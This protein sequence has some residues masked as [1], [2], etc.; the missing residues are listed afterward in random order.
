MET[1]EEWEDRKAQEEADRVN[2]GPGITTPTRWISPLQTTYNE[3]GQ[4]VNTIR[5]YGGARHDELDW[6]ALNRHPKGAPLGQDVLVY[7][8]AGRDV[9]PG[10]YNLRRSSGRSLPQERSH[11]TRAR[12]ACR[13][14]RSTCR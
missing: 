11:S 9:K 13:L 2:Q 10:E 5:H 12:R 14:G 8:A 7:V 4:I 6:D 3:R 1:L